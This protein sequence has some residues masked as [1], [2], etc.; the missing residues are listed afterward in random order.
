MNA[1]SLHR[2]IVISLLLLAVAAGPVAQAADRRFE[3]VPQSETQVVKVV[4]DSSIISSAGKQFHAGASL[5]PESSRKAWL[6]VSVKNMTAAPL[7]F[8]EDAIVAVGN[9]KTLAL[10][11][12]DEAL[13]GSKD[14][15]YVRD[16]CANAT[17]SSQ[18]NCT[19]DDFNRR[20]AERTAASAAE[21]K[22][23]AE[24]LGSGQLVVRQYQVDLPKHSKSVPLLIKVSITLGGEAISFDFKEVD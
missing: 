3:P 13:K 6:S 23:A 24:Q 10:T 8:G 22:P 9:G 12:A 18:M 17:S 21:A 20:Q 4:A 2:P 7:G 5:A 11:R 14:D 16:P 15:G 19:I 1:Q